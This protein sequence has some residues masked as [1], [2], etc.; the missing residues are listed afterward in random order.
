MQIRKKQ[1]GIFIRTATT[2][3]HYMNNQQ[4]CIH[5]IKNNLLSLFVLCLQVGTDDLEEKITSFE[6]MVQSMDIVAFNKV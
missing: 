5:L 6:D 4:V 2:Q 1:F 3:S